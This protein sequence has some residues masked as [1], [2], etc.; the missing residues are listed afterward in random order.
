M[1]YVAPR[2]TDEA[3]LVVNEQIA[4]WISR[5]VTAAQAAEALGLWRGHRWQDIRRNMEFWMMRRAG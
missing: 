3:V 5:G 1:G 2:S 4:W